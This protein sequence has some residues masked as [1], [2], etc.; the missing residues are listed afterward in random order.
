[1]HTLLLAIAHVGEYEQQSAKLSEAGVVKQKLENNQSR[2]KDQ[3]KEKDNELAMQ[4]E[5]LKKTTS[6]YFVNNM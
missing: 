3:L 2:L 5:K 4:E 1:M 6:T